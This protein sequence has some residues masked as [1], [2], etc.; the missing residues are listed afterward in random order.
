MTAVKQFTLCISVKADVVRV[1]H[2]QCQ[3]YGD[4]ETDEYKVRFRMDLPL[5]VL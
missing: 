3:S 5:L 1:E 4:P 2:P